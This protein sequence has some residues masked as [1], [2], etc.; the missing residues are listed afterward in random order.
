MCIEYLPRTVDE[1]N[2]WTKNFHHKRVVVLAIILE[3]DF[4]LVR[5]FSPS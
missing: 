2:N 5:L 3:Y 1:T 4:E